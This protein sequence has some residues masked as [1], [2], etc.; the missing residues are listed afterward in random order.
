MAKNEKSGIDSTGQDLKELRNELWVI[1]PFFLAALGFFLG[2]FTFKRGAGEVPMTVGFVTLIMVGMRLYHIIRPQSKIGEFNETGLAGEFDHIK[3][4]FKEET[5]KDHYKKSAGKEITF[6]DEK[7]AFMG[8]IG[9]FF[10]FLLCGYIVGCL[11]VIVWCSYY[12]GYREKLPIAIV[13]ASLFLI[14]YVV[15]YKLLEA[16]ADFGILL[17]PILSYL[18]II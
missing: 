13:V 8:I 18:N 7:K 16:P 4:E 17:E 3:D 14:V 12:Y 15:L 11:I 10:I 2:S 1:I 5:L 6:A 9:S